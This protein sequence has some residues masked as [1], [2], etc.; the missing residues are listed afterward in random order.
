MRATGRRMKKILGIVLLTIVLSLG[1]SLAEHAE[2]Q[3][4]PEFKKQVR[5]VLKPEFKKQVRPVVK[6][7]IK[8]E[9]KRQVR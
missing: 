2:M 1:T 7:V 8:P 4:R 5:P 3:F 6:P 9:F